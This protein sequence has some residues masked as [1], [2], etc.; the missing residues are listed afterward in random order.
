M[1]SERVDLHA[2]RLR[3]FFRGP[4]ELDRPGV[5]R[6]FTFD[7]AGHLVAAD[8]HLAPVERHGSTWSWEGF[9]GEDVLLQAAFHGDRVG[10]VGSQP[11][12]YRR[13]VLLEYAQAGDRFVRCRDGDLRFSVPC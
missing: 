12:R 13:A 10:L 8:R 9:Q 6:P 4:H 11:A 1:A 3:S 7:L 5:T 2:R